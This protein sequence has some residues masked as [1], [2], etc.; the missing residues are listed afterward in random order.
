MSV[1]KIIRFIYLI[2][3]MFAVGVFAQGP[4]SSPPAPPP[5]DFKEIQETYK[6]QL[7]EIRED[8]TQIKQNYTDEVRTLR[9]NMADKTLE[10]RVEAI[11]QL[12]ARRESFMQDMMAHRES[13]RATLEQR[14]LELKD[15]I[16][17]KRADMAT[18]LQER[19][20]DENKQR[21]VE[22]IDQRF[23]AL[24]EK[25]TNHFINVLDRLDAILLKIKV[26]AE[27]AKTNG[28]D[29]SAVEVAIEAAEEAIAEAR[30]AA[31]EQALK[32]YTIE[33]E[34]EETLRANVGEVRQQLGDDLK[35]V[36][37]IIKEA[38]AA[39]VDSLKVLARIQNVNDEV[40]GEE[41]EDEDATGTST[42]DNDQ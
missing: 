9:Q 31:E 35:G 25:L 28:A 6:E 1:K 4:V 16:E 19:V 37:E 42:E 22:K 26:R 3:V 10:E 18:H 27:K 17:A 2:P 29:I 13:F 5:P 33:I 39:V 20:S 30:T 41:E 15:A 12:R 32:T 23:D 36:R 40:E 38:R 34:G 11:E 24:N 7:G 14:K 21:V 8:R